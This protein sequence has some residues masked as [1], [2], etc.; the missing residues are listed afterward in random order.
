MRR[1]L[2]AA[3]CISV[4]L[5]YSSCNSDFVGANAEPI[6]AILGA[7]D[8]E[9]LPVKE[10]LAAKHQQRIEGIRFFTGTLKGRRMV[11]ACT[12]TGKV[13]AAMAT[14]LLIEHF[15]PRE[16]IFTGIA[17]GISPQL[18]PG[19]IVIAE[20]TAQHDL[21]TLTPEGLRNEGARSPVDG[22]RNPVLFPA[23]R[24][25]LKLA[26]LAAK[27][28]KL[29]KIKIETEHRPPKIIKGVVVTGDIFASSTT[30]CAE[31]R[32]TLG[33]DAVEM[34]GAA[35]AQICHQ[36]AVP[37]L[38]IR[39][40]SDRAGDQALNDFYEFRRIAAENSATLAIRIVELLSSELPI[41][42]TAKTR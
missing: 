32:N 14:T 39:G 13:N 7:C 10:Q 22:I 29:E 40:I 38:V 5:L 1:D 9:V 18:L 35:V 8:E 4:F 17:G 15:R 34:E 27:Q 28:V 16:V 37:H 33:A 36:Q 21:G 26:E 25:L 24:R 12:G 30:K 6:T 42:K 19:D 41:E 23:D 2:I 20:K 31:L 3:I 11:L